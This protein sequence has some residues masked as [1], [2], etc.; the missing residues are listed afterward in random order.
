[1]Q[2]KRPA[3]CPLLL[4]PGSC[5][6]ILGQGGTLALVVLC[7]GGTFVHISIVMPENPNGSAAWFALGF[8]EGVV[9]LG[10]KRVPM[11]AK[12]TLH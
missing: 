5:T 12:Q 9:V 6:P 11:P 7:C 1:M 4:P 8:E 10:I 3:C 2:G